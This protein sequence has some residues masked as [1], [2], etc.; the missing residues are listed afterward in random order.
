[1]PRVV[2]TSEY[3]RDTYAHSVAD[4]PRRVINVLPFTHEFHLLETRVNVYADVVDLYVI[5]ESNYTASGVPR[6]RL[7]LQRLQEGFLKQFQHKILYVPLGYFPRNARYN[8]WIMDALLR[9]YA[10]QQG[11]SRIKNLEENDVIVLND[12]DELPVREALLFLKVHRG[13]PEPVGF[14]L[15]H[16]VFG[17][18]W[19]GSDMRSHAFGACSVGMLLHFF[20]WQL[21]KLRSASSEMSHNADALNHF[22]YYHRGKIS[23]W[24]FG[25]KATMEPS[26]WHCSW[27][28]DPQG[29]KT[30]LEGAHWSDLPRWGAF[31]SKTTEDYIRNLTVRGMWFDDRTPLVPAPP[32]VNVWFAPQ[33]CLDHSERFSHLLDKPT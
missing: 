3:P 10:A 2:H 27:C 25:K 5:V 7:L 15:V 26:G 9:N 30:K 16:N 18:F 23:E 29:I 24:S 21:Y 32:R 6:D 1:M 13:Y 4:P 11:L 31:P 28:F 33:Y 22:R 17:F 14:H 20:D 8:G 19:L 12:A